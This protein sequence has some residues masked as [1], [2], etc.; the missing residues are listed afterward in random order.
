MTVNEIYTLNEATRIKNEISRA[1]YNLCILIGDSSAVSQIKKHIKDEEN[2]HRRSYPRNRT[3]S[4]PESVKLF[5]IRNI[6]D[7]YLLKPEYYPTVDKVFELPTSWFL[8]Y[9][10]YVKH[11]AIIDKFMCSNEFNLDTYKR[12]DY[13]KFLKIE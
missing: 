7:F 3:I 12:W 10:F 9:C 4:N 13:C 8:C 5:F 2:M 6:L 11:K 1:E